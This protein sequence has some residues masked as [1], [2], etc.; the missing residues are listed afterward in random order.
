MTRGS[1]SSTGSKAGV[2]RALA[3]V[4]EELEMALALLG[5][6]RPSDITRAHVGR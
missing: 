2:E 3:I 6:P 4:Q 1:R 5:T